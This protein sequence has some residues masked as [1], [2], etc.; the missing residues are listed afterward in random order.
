MLVATGLPSDASAYRAPGL[1]V[2]APIFF[3]ISM[4][5]QTPSQA[6]GHSSRLVAALALAA[7]ATFGTIGCATVRQPSFAG[8]AVEKPGAFLPGG[9]DGWTLHWS[10]EFDYPDKK[11]DERWN[12]QNSGSTHILSSR[13]RE[14]A[15]VSG[16]TLK[17]V[18][19]KEKRG[20]NEWTSG[21]VWTK[22]KFQYGYFECRYRY[23]AASATNNS[24]WL[25]NATK[26][27]PSAGKKFEIDIN[28]GHYP[29]R[30][31]T[32]IHNWSDFTRVNGK[33]TH[34]SDS[35][36]FSFGQNPDV[37][38]QLEIPVRTKRVRLSST[39]GSHFHIGEFR[40]YNVNP[41]GYPVTL[42]PT[43]DKDR[44]GLVNFARDPR[45]KVTV[46]G[47]FKDGEDTR[48]RLTDGNS[49]STWITQKEGPKFVEFELA[50]EQ[51]IGCVQFINGWNDRGN[52]KSLLENYRLEYHN[53]QRWVEMARYDVTE[54]DYNFARDFHTYGL[55]WTPTDLI[56]YFNGKEI[57]REKNEFCHS[58]TPIWLSLA[59]I[60]WA[61]PV[62]DA[63]D[64]T[65]MEVDYVRVYKR[66]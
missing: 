4:H 50:E 46:S 47:F 37:S 8:N 27:T 53:G 34:P 36:S 25:M 33:M 31:N 39:S 16:G 5:A 14:N 45:T 62:T 55:E 17:L 29:N 23:A 63:I 30:I 52:Y 10:D 42:S 24:F 2:F 49:T 13:W 22:E 6:P 9:P 28:E 54:G 35:R 3:P 57:R 66:R 18:N 61:G 20:G 40:L 41:Q 26:E 56:F 7:L 19:R 12:S 60:R 65:A 1:P 21:N 64:G 32:N 51:T 15:V 48:S 38:V 58:P 59:I 11:L 43:A 44:P